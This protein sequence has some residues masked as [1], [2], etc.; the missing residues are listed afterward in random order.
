MCRGS[1]SG[2]KQAKAENVCPEHRAVV[3]GLL[4]S[5]ICEKVNGTVLGPSAW[6]QI[7]LTL[8]LSRLL[9]LWEF[10]LLIS[11]ME[12]IMSTCTVSWALNMLCLKHRAM[13]YPMGRLFLNVPQAL[14]TKRIPKV[15]PSILHLPPPFLPQSSYSNGNHKD[16]PWLPFLPQFPYLSGPTNASK[17]SPWHIQPH[18]KMGQIFI[19]C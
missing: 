18:T 13:D 19:W 7:V 3:P 8:T 9:H 10:Q 12:I 5:W 11:K 2:M 15:S 1:R 17:L 4:W 16:H 6:N 14:K